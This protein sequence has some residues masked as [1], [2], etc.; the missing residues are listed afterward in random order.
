MTLLLT[1]LRK[2]YKINF[3]KLNNSM[4]IKHTNYLL[5]FFCMK[6]FLGYLQT[7]HLDSIIKTTNEIL[8]RNIALL[9]KVLD[10]KELM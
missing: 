1:Q 2:N 3:V 5:K 10:N 4:H 8:K 7:Q 6:Y 9:E